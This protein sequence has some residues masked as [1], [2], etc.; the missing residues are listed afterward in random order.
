DNVFLHRE[1]GGAG[2]VV[3]LVDF[4]VSRVSFEGDAGGTKTGMILGS[5][6][7]MSPEQ[8]RGE[9]LDGRSDIWSLGVVLF[10]MLTGRRPFPA[11]PTADAMVQVLTGPIPD[12]SSL[13]PGIPRGLSALV[14]SCLTRPVAERPAR[15][16]HIGAALLSYA[17]ST[18]GPYERLE[19]PSLDAELP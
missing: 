18:S 16:D 6:L 8:A 11:S 14:A 3:K 19:L 1:P 2:E 12:V 9:K 13:V 4:G 7:Y 10:E 17:L 15:A 5:P